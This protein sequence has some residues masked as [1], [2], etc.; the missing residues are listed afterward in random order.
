MFSDKSVAERAIGVGAYIGG[1]T[2]SLTCLGAGIKYQ[3]P[4][5]I[6]AGVTG[7]GVCG[8][9]ARGIVKDYLLD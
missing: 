5:A 3:S 8:A 1:I 4:V 9:M 6:L 2:G 7:L